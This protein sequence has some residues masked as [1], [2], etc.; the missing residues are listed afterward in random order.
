MRK[1]E[2]LVNSKDKR[3][4]FSNFL[5]LAVLQGFTYILPLLTMPYLVRVLDSNGF[6]LIMFAQAFMMFFVILT[7]YG[8]NLSAT[9]EVSIHRDSKEKLTEIY[10]SVMIIKSFL[11]ALSFIVLTVVIFSMEQFAGDVSVY[12]LSFIYVIGHAMFPVWYFQGIERM[13]YITAVNVIAKIIF[14]IS[15]FAIIREPDDYIFVPLLNGLGMIA[16]GGVAIWMIYRKLE[17]SFQIQRLAVLK[18][19]FNDSSQYFLSRVSVSIYTSSNAF[20][21]GILTNNTM[22][23]YYSVAEKLYGALQ[24]L[25]LPLNQALYPYVAKK[26]NIQLYK[27]IFILT[28]VANL[29]GVAFVFLVSD[30]IYLFL[31]GENASSESLIVFRVFLIAATVVVPSML[32][33]YPLLGALGYAKYANS[34]VFYGSMLHI[35]GI[36]VLILTGNVSIYSLAFMVLIT[37]TFV[38]IS[39]LFWVWRTEVWVKQ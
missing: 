33:G 15:I 23:G 37:E 17:Q 24:S 27:K 7:D 30:Y 5:S 20:V 14:T 26:K 22:V 21:L 29:L 9:R 4:L 11:V 2:Y 28:V 39:R 3:R 8:F 36:V 25:Y 19:Y 16:G 10:S 12:Y 35:L 6:G 34:S 18:E 38:F 1:L 32:I 31:F 13:K